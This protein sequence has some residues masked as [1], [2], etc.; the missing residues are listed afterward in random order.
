MRK[1]GGAQRSLALAA[2]CEGRSSPHRMDAWAC[3][4]AADWMQSVDC[5]FC[6]RL[7]GLAKRVKNSPLIGRVNSDDQPGQGGEGGTGDGS[8]WCRMPMQL[9]VM[10][11]WRWR[12]RNRGQGLHC[13]AGGL[14]EHDLSRPVKQDRVSG[15]RCRRPSRHNRHAAA[16][17]IL[18]ARCNGVGDVASLVAM[19]A[20]PKMGAMEGFSP[21]VAL[22]HGLSVFYHF[23]FCLF[24]F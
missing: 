20:G 4:V 3:E 12:I 9:G 24:R 14:P 2:S 1:S 7:P 10:Q 13:A 6:L 17:C 21:Q 11:R 16:R 5:L 23:M 18:P 15:S 22:R 19:D 8:V